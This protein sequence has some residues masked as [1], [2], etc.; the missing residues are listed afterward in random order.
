[1][2][3]SNL[4]DVE[5]YAIARTKVII[6]QDPDVYFRPIRSSPEPKLVR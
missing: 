5:Y 3:E 1:M 2:I 4:F 6:W